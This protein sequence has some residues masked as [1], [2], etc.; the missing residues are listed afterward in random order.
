MIIL[1]TM[2]I[3]PVLILLTILMAIIYIYIHTV[4]K[5]TGINELH[6]PY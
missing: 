4:Y 3:V 6:Y 5:Y 2:S 1:T